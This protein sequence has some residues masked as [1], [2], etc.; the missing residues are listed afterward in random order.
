MSDQ[1]TVKTV[2]SRQRVPGNL[3]MTDNTGN[4]SIAATMETEPVFNIHN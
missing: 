2:Y 4:M 1:S 3:S